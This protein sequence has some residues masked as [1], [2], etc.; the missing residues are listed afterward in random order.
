[1][2]RCFLQA[3]VLVTAVA[4]LC[5]SAGWGVAARRVEMAPGVVAA[6]AGDEEPWI[7]AVPLRGE[8]QL[9]YARR[10]TGSADNLP[11]LLV[12]NGGKKLLAG[13]RWK[14][15]FRLASPDLQQQLL[16][17]LFPGDRLE[18]TGWN[19]RVEIASLARGES[20]WT[21]ADWFTGRG[22]NFRQLR[23]ANRM[24]DDALAPGQE[25]W[26]P[27][28]LLRPSLQQALPA[29]SIGTP[30]D[31]LEYRQDAIGRYAAYRL[32]PGEALYSSVVV[33]FT[34]RV[35]AEDVNALA[36]EIA[37]RSGIADVTDIPIGYE[38]K[39]PLDLLQA[40]F[41]PPGDPRRAEYEASLSDS[42]RF[43]NPV[44]ASGLAGITVVLDAGHG[45]ADVGASVGSVWESLYVYDIMVRVKSLLETRT[46]A[47]VLPTVRDGGGFR[48]PEADVLPVSRGH[49][50]LTTPP[51]PI[52]DAKV[53]VN[54]RWY[55]ANSQYHKFTDGGEGDA[56]KVVFVS[57]HADS[58]HPSLRGAM[59]YVPSASLTAGRS[60]RSGIVYTSRA[61]VRAHPEVEFSLRE[62]QQSEGLSREMATR[63]IAA[64]RE[65]NLPVHPYKPVRERIIRQRGEFVPAVLRYNSI[66]AKMLVEV[67]NLANGEDRRLIQTRAFRQQV[68]EA[69]VAGILGYYGEDEQQPAGAG[70]QVAKAK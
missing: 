6:F 13:M 20:L 60:S 5:P 58:L 68:A 57:L 28:R 53:G 49:Q 48:V 32:Q 11:A 66:P 12:A 17:S 51:Y 15:P 56:K 19:H 33:R 9:A 18:V 62:R 44:Q 34:G 3:L 10:L 63:T 67:C 22:E 59:I 8:A 4:V 43:T 29:G 36:A 31:L 55:L 1:M 37:K 14:V 24:S 64:F 54:L 23:E 61:E 65:R 27:A 16:R 21:V 69:I 25:L 2:R 50:V 39:I 45:G 42:N 35:F 30:A 47:R 41:L 40:E 46:A 70:V 38:V 26:I 7:E 52:L